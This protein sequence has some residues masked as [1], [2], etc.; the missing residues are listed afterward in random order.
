MFKW[1]PLALHNLGW[2]PSK[3]VTW[4]GKK[5]SPAAARP[6]A[7]TGGTSVTQTQVTGSIL[8]AT[9]PGPSGKLPHR[10]RFPGG[11]V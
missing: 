2:H 11:H 5:G 1:K 10:C 8:Q 3:P 6:P 7:P 4:G 9:V